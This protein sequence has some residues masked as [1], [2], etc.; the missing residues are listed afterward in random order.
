MTADRRPTVETK[1]HGTVLSWPP[2]LHPDEATANRRGSAGDLPRARAALAEE[3]R[4]KEPKTPEEVAH[5][6]ERAQGLADDLEAWHALPERQ[7]WTRMLVHVARQEVAQRLRGPTQP[8]YVVDVGCGAGH[9]LLALGA[10]LG[11]DVS[12]HGV[13]PNQALRWALQMQSR[14]PVSCYPDVGRVN[15]ES[16]GLLV[17]IDVL[18]HVP[19]PESFLGDVAQRAPI[20]CLLFEATATHDTGTPLHLVENRGWHPGRVLEQHG[21][22]LA[23]RDQSGRVRVWRRLREAGGQRAGLLLCAY[24]SVSLRTAQSLLDL[25]AGKAALEGN[26]WRV[27][28]K[29]GDAL[30][31]R[32]RSIIL[33]SWH[34]ETNDDVCLFVDDD[35][36]FSAQDADRLTELCRGGHDIICGAYPVHDGSHLACRFLEGT[37]EVSFGPGQPPLEIACAATGFMAVHRRVF[38]HLIER[39]Y[40]PLCHAD[41]PWSFYPL[42]Q[43]RSVLTQDGESHEWLSEDWAFSDLARSAGFAVWL[44]PQTRLEHRGDCGISV[45][46]MAAMHA[47]MQQA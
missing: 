38:D 1:E 27:R 3:W 22:E 29:G 4:A 15:V 42:F 32:S 45:R 17:C 14:A 43:P 44:D 24:R 16:A 23:D 35:V 28:I 5:F 33:T 40:M 26:R 20:G 19:D 39:G 47:A 46:N 8:L 18:E 25:C 37:G 12:L 31:A 2:D 36:V 10:A 6:Y 11:R 30:I 34:R 7:D 21:W 13:E 9:D 41:Q